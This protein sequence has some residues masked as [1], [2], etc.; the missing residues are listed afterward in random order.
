MLRSLPSKSR[1]ASSRLLRLSKIPLRSYLKQITTTSKI[2]GCQSTQAGN[3]PATRLH[4]PPIFLP[5]THAPPRTG[6][7]STRLHASDSVDPSYPPKPGF[8]PVLQHS[9]HAARRCYSP[10]TAHQTSLPPSAAPISSTPLRALVSHFRPNDAV[11]RSLLTSPASSSMTQSPA[12]LV[13]A[14][15]KLLGKKKS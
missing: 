9:T 12:E 6:E 14:G 5:K 13:P 4:A 11:G 2:G 8:N 7:L 3:R 15:H 10:P 1:R